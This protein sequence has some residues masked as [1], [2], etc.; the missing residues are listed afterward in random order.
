[1]NA[2]ERLDRKHQQ[3]GI[4]TQ[5]GQI[6]GMRDEGPRMQARVHMRVSVVVRYDGENDENDDNAIYI[7]MHFF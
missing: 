7:Y 1:M 6:Q 4:N 2:K 5:I 3:N